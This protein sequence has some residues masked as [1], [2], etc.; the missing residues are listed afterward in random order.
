M[1]LDVHEA[2]SLLA[3]ISA[4]RVQTSKAL[5]GMIGSAL[6]R[7][8]ACLIQ[9]TTFQELEM[10]SQAGATKAV[11]AS[12]SS[13]FPASV[14]QGPL[15]AKTA[16]G[17]AAA[18]LHKHSSAAEGLQPAN[19]SAVLQLSASEVHALLL[20]LRCLNPR[21]GPKLASELVQAVAHGS[22]PDQ[23][24]STNR[25]AHWL[26]EEALAVLLA[27]A[28]LPGVRQAV[29]QGSDA[30]QRRLLEGCFDVALR[31]ANA[32]AA[33]AQMTQQTWAPTGGGEGGEGLDGGALGRSKRGKGMRQKELG[34]SVFEHSGAGAD[35]QVL[36]LKRA[37]Q[38]LLVHG[39]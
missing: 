15:P 2:V 16:P 34:L 32:Y 17:T 3:A 25:T 13:V 19:S 23:V 21:I 10:T 39:T 1:L 28:Q 29:I 18:A 7:L 37:R 5:V 4:L 30:E 24:R 33:A 22:L 9:P 36:A 20:A 38:A 26:P 31:H 27:L 35:S 6:S 14:S 12:T 8:L 11:A